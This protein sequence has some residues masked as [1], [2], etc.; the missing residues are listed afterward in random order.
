MSRRRTDGRGTA[1]EGRLAVSSDA[2][3][4]LCDDDVEQ[5]REALDAIFNIE[6]EARDFVVAGDDAY[7]ITVRSACAAREVTMR[8]RLPPDYP[9]CSPPELTLEGSASACGVARR[10]ATAA[11]H[12]Q[13]LRDEL[14][15][16]GEPCVFAWAEEVREALDDA[17]AAAGADAAAMPAAAPLDEDGDRPAAA[18]AHAE[19]GWT[20]EPAFPKYGQRPRAFDAASADAAH[21]VA[22]VE[23]PP[24]VD[25]KSTFIG[26]VARIESSEQVSWAYR[27]LL[28]RKD[29]A[30]ATHNIVA[31]RFADA[32]RAG[33]L[34][35]DNDDDG[36]D[37]AG[38]KLA[39]LLRLMRADGSF[40]M[41]SR[42]FGG[43]KLGPDRF[44]HINN[45]ARAAVVAHGGF[46]CAGPR[47]AKGGARAAR[48]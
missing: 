13:R 46:E 22:I 11:A 42:W 18:V 10:G 20:F 45:A 23:G 34:V 37:G 28:S 25:R 33:A 4:A 35:A 5:E 48:R 26:F 38:T 44:R 3:A 24:I 17:S 1:R 30:R 29:V 19:S 12:A 8:V 9:R 32:A 7:A 14:W 40:V 41:V 2:M 39:E 6:G 15:T 43:I 21:A 16:V 36:E 47:T 27:T 31:Y